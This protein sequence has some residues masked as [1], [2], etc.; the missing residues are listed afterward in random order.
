MSEDTTTVLGPSVEEWIKVT[1]LA[2]GNR[3]LLPWPTRDKPYGPATKRRLWRTRVIYLA[4][5]TI[6]LVLVFGVSSPRWHA[7]GI[8]LLFPGAGMFY[9]AGGAGSVLLNLI[10]FVVVIAAFAL[11][12]LVWFA[13]ANVF[14][15]IGVWLAVAGL[16]AMRATEVGNDWFAAVPLAGLLLFSIGHGVWVRR[17]FARAEKDAEERNAAVADMVMPAR[18]SFVPPQPF[19]GPELT[20]DELSLLRFPLELGLQPVEEFW[21]FDRMDQFRDAATRYQANFNGYLLAVVHY[22][23]MP[24]FHGYMAQAQRNLIDKVLLPP[25]WDYWRLENRWGNLRW[26]GDPV[27]R[28]NIM[29]SG[30]LGLHVGLYESVTGDTR[31]SEPGGLT[32]RWNENTSYV[33]DLGTMNRAVY[34]NFL[35]YDLGF[36]PCEPNWIYPV[37]NSSGMMSLIVHDR[38]HGTNYAGELSDTYRFA[39]EREF[40]A[41]DGTPVGLKSTRLGWNV[42]VPEAIK[43]MTAAGQAAGSSLASRDSSGTGQSTLFLPFHT[44]I[45]PDIAERDIVG[46]SYEATRRAILDGALDLREMS[47]SEPPV[48]GPAYLGLLGYATEYGDTEFADA[49]KDVFWSDPNSRLVTENG[50]SFLNWVRPEDPLQPSEP[51]RESVAPLMTQAVLLEGFF[52]RHGAG[53]DLINRGNPAAWNEGPLLAEVPYPDVLVARAVTDGQ[54]LDVVLQ[55]GGAGGRFTVSLSRLRPSRSYRVF[56]AVERDVHAKADGTAELTLDISG[57]HELRVE[58]SS[59]SADRYF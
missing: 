49:I 57:R 59:G 11:S 53:Y 29:L 41:P 26:S 38:L 16:S 13:T 4:I 55:P 40:V 58:P 24:A 43:N 6:G 21:G 42:T 9:P 2:D 30:W 15:P 44:A 36:F 10:W 19:V 33:H 35:R 34:D 23:R 27:I 54:A 46:G 1:R 50:V 20:K 47:A 37:C 8:G 48:G 22:S 32:F 51:H 31:Y 25:M 28:D 17:S 45:F 12:L 5:A 3:K 18:P 7:F 52:G 39:H 14:A 56:G